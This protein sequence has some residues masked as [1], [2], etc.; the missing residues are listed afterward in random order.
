MPSRLLRSSFPSLPGVVLL[1]RDSL[2]AGDVF[3][4][5]RASS[6]QDTGQYLPTLS[7]SSYRQVAPGCEWRRRVQH[8]WGVPSLGKRQCLPT[9]QLLSEAR[10]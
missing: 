8:D 4:G 7:V 3:G 2:P 6:E 5:E 1:H 9:R 10:T